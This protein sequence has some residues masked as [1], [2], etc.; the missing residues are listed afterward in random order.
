VRQNVADNVVYAEVRCETPGYTKAGMSALVAT[1]LLKA[2]FDAASLFYFNEGLDG[3]TTSGEDGGRSPTGKILTRT[4]ILLA[5]KR[6][7]DREDCARVISLLERYLEH[8]GARSV[9]TRHYPGMPNWWAPSD[10]VGFDLSGNESRDRDE[11]RDEVR[12][13]FK[14]NSPITVHAGEAASA[15]SVWAAVYGYHARRIGHGLRLRENPRL[16]RFCVDTGICMEM[17]PTS[18]MVTYGFEMSSTYDDYLQ[19]KGSGYPLRYYLEAGM[20]V[21]LNTDNRALHARFDTERPESELTDRNPEMSSLTD[22]YLRA[23]RLSGGLTRWEVLKIIRSG[24]KN[25]FLHR[26]EIAQLLGAVEARMFG[27]VS[28]EPGTAWTA[29]PAD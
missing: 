26:D 2:S 7:K 25:A 11:I 22:D 1:Q 12:R 10:V 18:N 29:R 24:F 21:C 23:A 15:E 14:L 13:L 9:L 8:D 4:N 3:S 20:E 27:L 28:Q 5:A 17:C 19:R 16:L 6:H